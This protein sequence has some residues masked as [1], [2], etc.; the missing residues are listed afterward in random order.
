[1]KSMTILFFFILVT[2]L[3]TALEKVTTENV[4]PVVPESIAF[5]GNRSPAIVS[6]R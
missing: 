4:D 6:N 3:M 5:K 2:N 1:M